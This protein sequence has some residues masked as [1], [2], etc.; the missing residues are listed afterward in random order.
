MTFKWRISAHRR[1]LVR[2]HGELV[3][4]QQDWKI[5]Q[6]CSFAHFERAI[7]FLSLFVKAR[8]SNCSFG[9]S[10]EKSKKKSN[11][12]SSVESNKKSDH[13][14]ALFKRA[15]EQAITWLLFWKERKW[16]MSEWANERLPNP[17]K[18]VFSKFFE[19]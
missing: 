3:G 18:I 13:S 2:C 16:V 19:S 5:A 17:A 12:C 6:F 1:L 7:P 8:K 9:R 14:F 15:N 10:F 4:P 11:I